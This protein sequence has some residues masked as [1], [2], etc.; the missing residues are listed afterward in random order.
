MKKV[1][2]CKINEMN[3]KDNGTPQLKPDLLLSID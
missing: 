3:T 1:F 2:L